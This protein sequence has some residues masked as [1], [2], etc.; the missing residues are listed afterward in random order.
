M[1]YIICAEVDLTDEDNHRGSVEK[2]KATCLRVLSEKDNHVTFDIRG[3]FHR[4]QELTK[5][6]CID[7]IDSGFTC[8]SIHHSY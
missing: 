4:Q 6:M 5:K 2:T 1:G 8:F 7:L 3:D